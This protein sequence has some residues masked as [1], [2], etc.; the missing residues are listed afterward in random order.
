MQCD[1]CGKHLRLDFKEIKV[2]VLYKEYWCRNGHK[3]I[4]RRYGSVIEINN[5]RIK[6]NEPFDLTEA[7]RSEARKRV[8]RDLLPKT[9]FNKAI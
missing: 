3:T 4:Y 2:D 7:I 1:T 6:T 8:L 9:S 5:K